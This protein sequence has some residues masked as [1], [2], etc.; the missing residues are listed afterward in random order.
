[1]SGLFRFPCANFAVL[2]RCGIIFC[3]I[4][5]LLLVSCSKKVTVSDFPENI[6]N[7]LDIIDIKLS[8]KSERINARLVYIDSLKTE[9]DSCDNSDV[10]AR[11]HLYNSLL[12][13]YKHFNVDSLAFYARQAAAYSASNGRVQMAE[14]YEMLDMQALLLKGHTYESL[15]RV[16]TTDVDNLYPEN[17][18]FFLIE[19]WRVALSAMS[20]FSS[21]DVNEEYMQRLVN[22]SRCIVNTISEDHE[23]YHV[24]NAVVLLSEKNYT[25]AVSNLALRLESMDISDPLY[26]DYG[27]VLAM[28]EYIRGNR[29]QW[30]Y[31]QSLVALSEVN[32]L[33]LDGEALRQLSAA[34]V[35]IGDINHSLKY[36]MSSQLDNVFSGAIMRGIQTSDSIP[37]ISENY[38]NREQS[39]RMML[40]RTI[41]LL[42]VLVVVCGVALF[43]HFRNKKRFVAMNASLEEANERK[44]DS[45]GN[46][47]TLCAS[48]ME[49][50]EDL[51]RVV[52]RKLGA[53]QANELHSLAKSGKFVDEQRRMF[54][55]VFD[56]VF[57]NMYPTFVSD[58]NSLCRPDKQI[59][60]TDNGKLTPELRILAFMRLGTDDGTQISRLLGLSLNTVYTY[61]NRAKNRAINRASF[62]SDIMNIGR[63]G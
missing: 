35:T 24:A 54:Y 18:E 46:F 55:D 28:V 34:L 13:A 27:S 1:M 25:L 2:L 20:L 8:E 16:D 5:L 17:R 3:Y 42:I 49:R 56:E 48:C 60:L 59:L 10:D 9:I 21:E 53:G 22:V 51:N 6:A 31:L 62:E 15:I 32:R 30:M 33:T 37:V 61:R 4:F 47:I 36:L 57:L 11:I 44:E 38:Q 7:A 12:D 58:V 43:V 14:R 29:V 40:Y 63:I 41:A 23:F 19:A 45:L 26:C 50:I 39:H 52:V